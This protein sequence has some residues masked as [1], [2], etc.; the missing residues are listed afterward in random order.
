MADGWLMETS[1]T[2]RCMQQSLSVRTLVQAADTFTVARRCTGA[3]TADLRAMQAIVSA[4]WV[5]ETA[6]SEKV[7]V[8]GP[9]LKQNVPSLL[10]LA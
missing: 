4:V 8:W 7:S 1:K 6:T 3:A 9:A 10:T 2:Q 5:Q